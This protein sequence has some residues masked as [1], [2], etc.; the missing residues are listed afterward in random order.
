M[1]QANEGPKQYTGGSQTAVQVRAVVHGTPL[2]VCR[3][4]K[5]FKSMKMAFNESV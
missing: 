4:S 5:Q 2:V 1:M 3:E